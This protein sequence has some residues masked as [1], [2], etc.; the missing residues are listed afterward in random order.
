M[1]ERRIT[2]PVEVPSAMTML[3]RACDVLRRAE[4]VLLTSHRRP[5]GDG[6]G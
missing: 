5:D 6:T 3:Y 4:R 2:V 1:S